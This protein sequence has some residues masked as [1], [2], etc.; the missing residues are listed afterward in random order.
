MTTAAEASLPAAL[1]G[2]WRAIAQ[3][4]PAPGDPVVRVGA[5]FE[6]L[7][8]RMLCSG[9]RLPRLLVETG[10]SDVDT[11]AR[12]VDAQLDAGPVGDGA[13]LYDVEADLDFV[14]EHAPL[15]VVEALSA[16]IAALA[17]SI[18]PHH[19]VHAELARR[20][21]GAGRADAVEPV[22]ARMVWDLPLLD[23]LERHGDALDTALR[24]RLVARAARLVADPRTARVY[25]VER[26][27]RLAVLAQDRAFLER[28]RETLETLSAEEIANSGDD[29]PPRA[30]LA[31]GLARIGAFD[32]AMAELGP[33]DPDDHWDA[34][35]RLLPFA[36]NPAVRARMVDALAARA[37]PRGRSWWPLVE[38]A[39]EVTER[40]LAACH[41]IADEAERSNALSLLVEHLDEG[42]ARRVCAWMLERAAALDPDD[43]GWAE[44]WGDVLGALTEVGSASLL[45]EA[46]RRRLLDA[47]PGRDPPWLWVAAAPFVPDDRVDVVLARA[48]GGLAAADHYTTREA[49]IAVGLPLLARAPEERAAAWLELAAA[50]MAGTGIEGAGL[51]RLSPWSPAQQRGIVLARLAQ[52]QR[53]FLP[54]WLLRPWLTALSWELPPR[55][56]PRWEAQLDAEELGRGR[57]RAREETAFPAVDPSERAAARRELDALTAG[58]AWPSGTQVAAVFTALGRC[59][60]EGAV[61]AAAGALAELVGRAQSP[62]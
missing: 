2:R 19:G 51:A 35:L 1:L 17:F 48:H 60:G 15:E 12:C 42:R 22:L 32:E 36:P 14:A 46:A 4:A 44:R 8:A 31:L 9:G 16:K 45:D 27:V 10:L 57:A 38:A 18:D 5:W 11:L 21:L 52:H 30:T 49:W 24:G 7:A 23:W 53:S 56:W 28:A 33:L 3:G 54:T 40:A 41:A 39:P 62:P 61:T 37:E 29:E 34:L 20:L 25:R 59:A 13:L 55:L 58:T 50:Q 43:P 47:L 6:G 26:L